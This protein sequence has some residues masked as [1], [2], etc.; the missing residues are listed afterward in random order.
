MN[1]VVRV[2]LAKTATAS[3]IALIV[4]KITELNWS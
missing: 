2:G 1:A 3:A 4:G